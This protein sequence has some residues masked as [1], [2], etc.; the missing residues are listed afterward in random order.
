MWWCYKERASKVI[1]GDRF[2]RVGLM[3]L[4]EEVTL[5]LKPKGFKEAVGVKG[6]PRW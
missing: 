4:S 3:G 6:G 5:K 1:K 2:E